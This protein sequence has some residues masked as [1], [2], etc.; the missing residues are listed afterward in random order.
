M[1]NKNIAALL[2]LCLG[3]FGIH[4]FYLGQ[5]GWGIT[6]C[7]LAFFAGFSAILGLIDALVF[8]TM[9]KESFDFKYNR[10]YLDV[11]RRYPHD[12]DFDRRDRD[13]RRGY[14]GE[15]RRRT[16]QPYG[17]AEDRPRSTRQHDRAHRRQER[18]A[19]RQSPGQSRPRANP[20][21]QEGVQKFRD[22]DYLGAIEAF[23]KALEI[24]PQDIAVHFNLACTYS[25]TENKKEAFYHL[26]RATAYGFKDF[27][28][29]REH[30]ALAWLRIQDEFSEFAANNSRLPGKEDA[31]SATR[32]EPANILETTPDLLDQLK[33]LNEMRRMGILTEEQYTAQKRKLTG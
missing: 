26:D 15:D 4:R 29:V 1:K 13:Y 5:K 14:R 11:K 23:E 22:Y 8:L 19:R 28:R 20:F 12:S 25:L 17:R 2:A 32:N 16:E 18:A 7:I 10:K 30:D 9:D 6:Y 33:K 3:I 24:N 27:K 31:A 21:R